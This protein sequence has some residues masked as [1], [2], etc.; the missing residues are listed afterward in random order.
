[1]GIQIIQMVKSSKCLEK[2]LAS[3][4]AAKAMWKDTG[5]KK[6]TF[7]STASRRIAGP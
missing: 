5:Y 6:M 1:M 2:Y 3:P 4:F 7:L